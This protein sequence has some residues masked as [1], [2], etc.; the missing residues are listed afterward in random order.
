[1]LVTRVRGRSAEAGLTLWRALAYRRRGLVGRFRMPVTRSRVSDCGRRR[2]RPAST[3]GPPGST[4][5][6]DQ[7]EQAYF[8]AEQP[9][10]RQDPRL[11]PAHAHPCRPRHPRCPSSQG[12][13]RALRLRPR[14]CCPRSTGCVTAPT[15]RQRSEQ[16]EEHEQAPGSSWCTPTRPTRA[17]VSR[18]GSVLLSP[19]PWDPRSCATAPSDA[20]G[21]WRTTGSICSR[22]EQTWSSARIPLLHRR[23][24]LSWATTWTPSWLESCG[25]CPPRRC[26]DDRR[27][28]HSCPPRGA[29]RALPAIHLADAASVRGPGARGRRRPGST[30]GT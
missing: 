15:S 29:H 18:R 11:P 6:G 13:L 25:G 23:I 10:S 2:D 17:R 28:G 20:C 9:S 30:D 3:R 21:P 24:R 7:R 1:M 27:E 19:R 8:P 5:Y 22:R 16:Q 4:S 14:A 26:R 12:P